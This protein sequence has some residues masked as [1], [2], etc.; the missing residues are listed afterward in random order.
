VSRR[1][2][3]A[4]SRPELLSRLAAE[5]GSG[6][7]VVLEQADD[8]MTALDRL[9]ASAWD[10]VV[11]LAEGGRVPGLDLV[12]LLEAHAIH[13]RVPVIFVGGDEAER[14]AALAAG[15]EAAL[16]E[17]PAP[18]ALASAVSELLGSG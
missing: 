4:G 12:R 8:V 11:V 3:L 2:L 6:F 17:A 15:A 16:P 13:G 10:L 5:I 7:D 1:V 9:P 14:R 18:A